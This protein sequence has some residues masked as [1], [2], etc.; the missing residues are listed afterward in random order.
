VI[1]AV[2]L[3]ATVIAVGSV[4]WMF[5]QGSMTITAEDYTESLMNMTDV[6]SERFIVEHVSYN[7]THIH[8]WVF[9][10]GDIDIE[11]KVQVGDVTYSES[12]ID[13]ATGEMIPIDPIEF[14]A[15]TGDTL[16]IRTYSWRGNNANYRYFVS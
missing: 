9:N 11:I 13:V 5:S 8:V 2:I 7:G 16:N 6:I 12:W 4:V 3:S 1:S 14:T 10:Y 15:I